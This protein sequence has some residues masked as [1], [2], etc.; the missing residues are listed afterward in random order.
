L[1]VN[2]S[3]IFADA[4]LLLRDISGCTPL[5]CAVHAGFAKITEVLSTGVPTLAIHME[6]GVGDTLL[7]IASVK[8]TLERTT[9]L[10]NQRLVNPPTLNDSLVNTKSFSPRAKATDLEGE[11]LKLRATIKQLTQEGLLVKGTNIADELM[12]FADMMDTKLEEAKAAD[13]TKAAS[14]GANH[15]TA[16]PVSGALYGG[17]QPMFALP[18]LLSPPPTPGPKSNDDSKNPRDFAARGRTLDVVSKAVSAAPGQ[19]QLVRLLDV[20]KSIQ[21]D[22]TRHAKVRDMNGPSDEDELQFDG[23]AEGKE[24]AGSLVLRH[25][26]MGRDTL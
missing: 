9:E 13:A 23:D 7:E 14:G 12:K 20:Q 4:T 18:M 21:S 24:R 16:Q 19:R 1:I 5:H 25:I 26:G 15:G 6:D 11:L 8:L 2:F 10:K 22:L 17:I 3:K